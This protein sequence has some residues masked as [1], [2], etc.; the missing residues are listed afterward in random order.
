MDKYSHILFMFDVIWLRRRYDW[1]AV[2]LTEGMNN[3][4][5]YIYADVSLRT[6]VTSFLH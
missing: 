5:P 4:I 3:D 2:D 1:T 6:G